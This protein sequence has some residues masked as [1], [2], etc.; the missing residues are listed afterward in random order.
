MD[1]NESPAPIS[2]VL[3]NYATVDTSQR[4]IEWCGLLIAAAQT[5]L[6]LSS[7]ST[8]CTLPA[9][10]FIPEPVSTKLW[11]FPLALFFVKSFDG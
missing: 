6:I 8:V 10:F 7:G 3:L 4:W 2:F 9:G 1:D 11:I 5:V